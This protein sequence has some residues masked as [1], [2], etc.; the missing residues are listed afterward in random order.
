[1]LLLVVAGL[2]ACDDASG[3][4][5]PSMT[6][7]A[8]AAEVAAFLPALEDVRS[9]IL[10]TSESTIA[11]QLDDAVAELKAALDERR[12]DDVQRGTTAARALAAACDVACLP[13]PEVSVI[14]LTLDHADAMIAPAGAQ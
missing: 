10:P 7:L 4:E 1:M 5:R 13:A 3:P 11:V 12:A 14:G 2:A 8:S 9:R 6:M